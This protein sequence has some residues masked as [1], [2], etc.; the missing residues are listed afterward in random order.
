MLQPN[1]GL[2][3]LQIFVQKYEPAKI[4]QTKIAVT[5]I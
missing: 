4:Q 2:E 1:L 3:N 5:K